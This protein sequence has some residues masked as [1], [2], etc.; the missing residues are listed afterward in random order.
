MSALLAQLSLRDEPLEDLR[1]TESLA[2]DLLVQVARDVEARVAGIVREPGLDMESLGVE[3]KQEEPWG[4]LFPVTDNARTD[5]H[6][7]DTVPNHTTQITGR[8]STQ[9]GPPAPQQ[10]DPA[11]DRDDDQAGGDRAR[12]ER[13]LR[14]AVRRRVDEEGGADPRHEVEPGDV[15]GPVSVA[16][17]LRAE[18]QPEL[19]GVVAEEHPRQDQ[20]RGARD[21]QELGDSLNDA[22]QD[23]GAD[24]HRA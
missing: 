19:L 3:L 23:S 5:Y 12:R 7:T 8:G 13:H 6:S 24:A 15:L 2:A 4:K 9:R 11:E 20:V 14:P 21:R 16:V 22:K 1:R 10:R 18:R 17:V